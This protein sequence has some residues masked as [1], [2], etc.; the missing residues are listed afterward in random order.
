MSSTAIAASVVQPRPRSIVGTICRRVLLALV[1]LLLATLVASEGY[2]GEG[3]KTLVINQAIG[4]RGFAFGAWEV[5]ALGQK[6]RD[7]IAQPSADLSPQAQ[8][9]LVIAY[10]DAIAEIGRLNG[11]IERIYANPKE[12]NPAAAAAGL[13]ARLEGLRSDQARRRPAVE[14]TL[15]TQT[16][17]I[18]HEA[19]LTTLNRVW[20]PVR[21][22]FTE[23]PHKLI[24]SPRRR[25]AVEGEA[26]L[27][28]TVPLDQIEGIESA[29]ETA[30][31]VSALVEG[32][33]GI[34]S[35]PTMIVEIASLEWVLSTIAHEWMHT[36][37]IFYPLGLRYFENRDTRT[38]NETIASIVGDEIGRLAL[39]RF[40]PELAP[41]PP[42]PRP[43]RG[44]T[45][46]PTPGP[47]R[48]Q[49]GPFMRETR[50]T[51]DKLL[52][53][54][55]VIEAEEYMEARRQVLVA[56][57]YAIRKLNQAY[58]AF[59]GSYAVGPAG[60]DPIGD[61]LRALRQRALSLADFVRIVARITSVA[62]LDAALAR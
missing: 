20:P 6:A 36:Y 2:L 29:V 50:L 30:L 59:H 31:D 4:P 54:G 9:D 18:L 12:T 60:T 33:G 16:A 17:A 58:F 52:A 48:F 37:L 10:F 21:F 7:L 22:Q 49:F 43:A 34:S 62:E 32:T 28:P 26:F 56:N 24:V 39:E 55:Q 45:P 57:G 46:T 51:V 27:Q 61:K 38:L 41:P 3:R 13:A 1:C 8:H 40:Y 42:P 25:I 47:P 14:A 11:E 35:Y 19:G 15:E 23:S 44:V 53:E 5:Q